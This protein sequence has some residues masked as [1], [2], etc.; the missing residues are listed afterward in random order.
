M[1][2]RD[3]YQRRV[4]GVFIFT[5]KKKQQEENTKKREITKKGKKMQ[6]NSNKKD[7]SN[8]KED[9]SSQP[10]SLLSFGGNNKQYTPYSK[11]DGK[12]QK[13]YISPDR[14][15]QK[16]GYERISPLLNTTQNNLINENQ[17]AEELRVENLRLRQIITGLENK[18]DLLTFQIDEL[19]KGLENQRKV[20]RETDQTY[21]QIQK[22]S[23]LIKFKQTEYENIELENKQLLTIIKDKEIEMNKLKQKIS[24]MDLQIF[25]L[26]KNGEFEQKYVQLYDEYQQGQSQIQALEILKTDVTRYEQ[27]ISDLKRLLLTKTEENEELK[28]INRN[29]EYQSMVSKK[30][31]SQMKETQVMHQEIIQNLKDQ[32]Q[33][34]E[35]EQFKSIQLKEEITQEQL[36]R[37]KELHQGQLKQKEQQLENIQQ[38]LIDK[39]QQTQELKRSLENIVFEKNNIY[40]LQEKSRIQMEIWKDKALQVQE[41]KQIVEERGRKEKQQLMEQ[42]VR[43]HSAEKEMLENKIQTLK[44][45][46]IDT[47]NNFVE[48]NLRLKEKE[49][50][51]NQLQFKAQT[52]QDDLVSLEKKREYDEQIHQNQLQTKEQLHQ[53]EVSRAQKDFE[54]KQEK[55]K[56]EIHVLNNL[57]SNKAQETQDARV[58]ASQ[59]SDK[60]KQAEIQAEI[61]RERCNEQER[62]NHFER[63]TN[64]QQIDYIQRSHSKE[65]EM[66][67]QQ[68]Q[69]LRKSLIQKDQQI[70]NEQYNKAQLKREISSLS[71]EA[72]K[73][74]QE[75]DEWKRE[76]RIVENLKNSQIIE[77]EREKA[78]Q[79]EQLRTNY[80]KDLQLAN[81]EI[82]GWRNIAY[83]RQQ[84]ANDW[85]KN[86]NRLYQHAVLN[87]PTVYKTYTFNK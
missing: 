38:L 28:K 80:G 44:K 55:L 23:A 77:K 43:S 39:E 36:R 81:Q 27:E 31:E 45:S 51:I 60:K 3:R 34:N 11:L 71:L 87:P 10:G 35:E 70:E 53:S 8:A 86:Y 74:Q 30:Q 59:L 33:Q 13:S 78:I 57:M 62:M 19:N 83:N 68:K 63:I 26:K 29:L 64:N 9:N 6:E 69:Q 21:N 54:L 76:A 18:I 56:S 5:K 67:E 50:E 12:Q 15:T 32:L 65:L 41:E 16:K 40:Q 49:D 2:I 73:R 7:L 17:L 52:L 14:P 22:Q 4:H 20:V 58:Q 24:D 48:K 66:Q 82:M 25:D 79:M 61:W 84:E 47:E 85:F 75:A 72:Q 46:L 42:M 1:C 37:D